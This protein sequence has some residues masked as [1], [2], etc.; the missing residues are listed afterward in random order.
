MGPGITP[1]CE[2]L[3]SDPQAHIQRAK[4]YDWEGVK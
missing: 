1:G 3:Y 2:M 4:K